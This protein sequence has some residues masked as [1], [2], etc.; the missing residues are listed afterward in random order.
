MKHITINGTGVKFKASHYTIVWSRCKTRE[1]IQQ[2]VKQ[3]SPK[4][5]C[6]KAMLDEFVAAAMEHNGLG[7]DGEA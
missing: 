6:T 3:L 2:W 4:S 1:D 5:W 7:A